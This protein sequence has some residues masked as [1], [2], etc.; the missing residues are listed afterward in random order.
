[1]LLQ[2]IFLK[3]IKLINHY[4]FF[5]RN[6]TFK[7][8]KKDHANSPFYQSNSSAAWDY[9]HP[10][11]CFSVNFH[12]GNY[13]AVLFI[14]IK[15]WTQLGS[16]FLEKEGR[17]YMKMENSRLDQNTVSVRLWDHL[18]VTDGAS[19]VGGLGE[20]WHLAERWA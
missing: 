17:P 18:G 1:M 20:T 11:M 16:V 14:Q 2:K 8:E 13:E 19:T 7:I 10:D 3:F 9:E 5:K 12:L 6:K 4:I 15:K